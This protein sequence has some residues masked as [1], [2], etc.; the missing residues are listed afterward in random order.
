[1]SFF[2]QRLGSW[3]NVGKVFTAAL[4]VIQ[5]WA[6]YVLFWE[7]PA[8][9]NRET[10]ADLLGI[11]A[12]LQAFALL[13]TV[14]IT[15]FWALLGLLLPPHVWGMGDWVAQATAWLV[16]SGVWAAV[17]HLTNQS[18]MAWSVGEIVAWVGGY[19]LSWGLVWAVVRRSAA[20]ANALSRFA[21]SLT[22]LAQVYLALD[23]LSLLVIIGRNLA[24]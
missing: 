14:L 16:L 2:H 23:L 6:F 4:I 1:M 17:I 21:A 7:I 18:L 15:L 5:L 19:L 9:R 10:T 11:I 24:G 22:V 13:E 3:L 8:L 20:V 12:Y